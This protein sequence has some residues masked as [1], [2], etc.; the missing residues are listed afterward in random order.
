MSL[1]FSYV[2]LRKVKGLTNRNYQQF[3]LIQYSSIMIKIKIDICNQEEK[4]GKR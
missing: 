4:E 3:T 2:N 1:I